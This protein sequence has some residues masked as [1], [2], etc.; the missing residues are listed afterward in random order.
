MKKKL[1]LFFALIAALTCLFAISSN[2]TEV[3][4]IYYTF[5][6]NKGAYENYAGTA[7]VNTNNATKCTLTE[8]IIPEYVEYDKD[9]DGVKEKY[10]VTSVAESAFKKSSSA[11]PMTKMV[12]PKTVA[13]IGKFVLQNQTNL[14]TLIIEARGYNPETGATSEFSFSNAEFMGCTGLLTVDMSEAKIK[15]VGG[16]AFK[17]CTKLQSV[18]LSSSTTDIGQEAFYG[19]TSLTSIDSLANVETVGSN[20]FQK[21]SALAGEI[22]LNSIKTVGVN[23]F[24]GCSSITTIDMTGAELESLGNYAFGDC[25]ALTSVNLPLTLETIGNYAFQYCKLLQEIGSLDNVTSIGDG[26][27]ISCEK[28]TSVGSLANVETVGSGAFKNCYALAQAIELTSATAIGSNAFLSCSKITSVNMEGASVTEIGSYA[29]KDCTLLRTVVLPEGLTTVKGEA[30]NNSGVTSINIPSSLKVIESNAFRN[31]KFGGVVVL[32][33]LN[34]IGNNAFNGTDITGLVIKG[35]SV[36]STGTNAE[37]ANCSKLEFVILPS[38]ITSIG[39]Y[40][41]SGCSK[42]KYIVAS[43]N[44]TSVSSAAGVPATVKAII[45]T[46]S[47]TEKLATAAAAF[48]GTLASFDTYNPSAYPSSRTVYYGVETKDNVN[49]YKFT[50][51]ESAWCTWNATT[52]EK[53]NYKPVV[54]PVGYSIK[55]N[56]EVSDGIIAGFLLD[57]ASREAYEGIFGEISLGVFMA[58]A[59][60]FTGDDFIVNGVMTNTFGVQL[61]ITAEDY[62]KINCTV[63]GMSAANNIPPI[64][65]ALYALDSEGNVID[66][67]QKTDYASN[68]FANTAVAGENTLIAVTLSEVEALVSDANNKVEAVVNKE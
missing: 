60:E 62:S 21:C 59:N 45:L 57:Q 49:Y 38:T 18:S 55:E 27:F 34:S 36:T 31:C 16:Y 11:L 37:F 19:C 47:D 32:N 30:F 44:I 13:S 6:V 2:A 67:V 15:T 56:A 20:A 50:D 53:V 65:F 51:L 64:V 43:E 41:F 46:G 33:E 5:T 23:G 29:F 40:S 63:V 61:E 52:N 39:N 28:I 8:V 25:S 54:N 48:G 17:S 24:Q 3:D 42:L 26:A 4:G 1:L 14:Q 7:T 12:I 22:K 68:A 35:G 9:G 66:Y 58:N 10:L